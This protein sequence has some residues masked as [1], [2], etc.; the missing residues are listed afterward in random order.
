MNFVIYPECSRR[1][2]STQLIMYKWLVQS[3]DS[4]KCSLSTAMSEI[5][6]SIWHPQASTDTLAANIVTPSP[7]STHRSYLH[8]ASQGE[9]PYPSESGYSIHSKHSTPLVIRRM[10]I[11]MDILYRLR[12][13]RG[14]LCTKEDGRTHAYQK[15]KRDSEKKKDRK[16]RY[17]LCTRILPP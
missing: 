13:E 7:P 9:N 5:I 14:T 10:I 4:A 6:F 16:E 17:N 11:L 12:L 15:W 1:S 2:R 3:Y 8:H